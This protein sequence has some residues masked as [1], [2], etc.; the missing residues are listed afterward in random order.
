M[1]LLDTSHIDS[2]IVG[3]VDP[4]I[5]AFTTGTVPEYLKVGDT[6]RPVSVRLQ[7]WR[8][9]FPDLKK[10]YEHVAKTN[11]GKYFRD[12]AV[13][14]Y[15]ETI[16]GLHRLL[17][18]EL[19]IP[20][21]SRE[22]FQHATNEDIDKAI[23]DIEEYASK[24]GQTRYQFYSE[25]RLPQTEHYER[26]ETFEPRPNQDDTI[27]AFNVAREKG[28]RHL[29]MYAVM[30]FGK[31]FT[32]MCCATEM[33]AKVVLIVSA[34]ADVL[35]EWKYTVESH[36]RFKDYIFLDSADL[37][38]EPKAITKALD[39]KQCV[40]VFLTLQD[41]MGD[42]IKAKHKDLFK[43]TVDLL[44]VDET[45][46][47]ARAEEY[48][49]VLRN[50]KLSAAQIRKEQTNLDDTLDNLEQGLDQLKTLKTDTTLH[51][52]GTP[53]RILMGSEFTK[54]DII[55]FY[56]FTDIIDD[57]EKWDREHLKEDDIKEW[58]NPYY[59]FPQ[60]IRFAFHPNASSQRLLQ[61]MRENGLTAALNE[62]FRPA[63]I[64]QDTD[65]KYKQFAHPQEV[66]DLLE[67]IDGSQQEEDLLS[68]LDYSKLKEGKMCHHMVF[69]LP[70]CASCDAMETLLKKQKR[71]FK[72]LS[73]YEIINI[74][75]KDSVFS[76]NDDVKKRITEAEQAGKKT[77]SLTVNKMLTGCTVPEWDTMLFLK[78]VS[79]P[80]EYDQAIF[81]L[82]NQFVKRFID[83]KGDVVKYNMKP[84]TLLVDFDVNRMFIMQEQKSKIYNVN[85]T[86]RGNDELEKRI[87]RELQISPIIVSNK[88]KLVEATPVDIMD[89]V[90]QYSAT[91]TV[92]DE[93]LEIP[94]DFDLLQDPHI[95][96]IIEDL[97]PI[98]A[99]KGITIQPIEGEGDDYDFPGEQLPPSAGG[100]NN[101]GSS[102]NNESE[103][104]DDKDKRLATYFSQILFFALLT[105]KPAHSLN[106]IIVA[107]DAD[108]D[109]RRIAKHVGLNSRALTYL[110]KRLNP[111]HLSD[112]DYKIQN[113]ND[114]IR[115]E[116]VAPTERVEIALN[117]FGRLS[118]SEIVTP[119]HIADKMVALLPENEINEKTKFLDIASKE[120]EFA[121]ALYKRFGEKVKDNIHALPTSTLTYEFTRKVFSLL[122]IP[123]RNIIS[124]FNSYDLIGQNKEQYCQI[125][126]NMKFDVIVG[127]PPYQET[128][129]KKETENGQKRV[130][131]IFHH[132]QLLSDEIVTYSV[133]IYPGG[134]WI[135]QFGKGMKEFGHNQINDVHLSKM[136]YYPDANEIF[137]QVGISDGLSIVMK[138]KRKNL[139]GFSY[140]YCENGEPFEIEKSKSIGDDI[141]PL[142]P[143]NDCIVEHINK[144]VTKKG[145]T[146]LNESVLSQKLFS[147]E[148]DFVQSN[149]TLVRAYN[150]GDFFDKS[151]EIKLLTNDKAGKAGRARWY[152]VQRDVITSGLEYLDRWKVVVSS[153]NAGGQKRSNQL[154]ILDNYSAFGRVKVALKTFMTQRE[155][156]NFYNYVDSELIRFAFL[157]TDES[158]TSLAKQV[159]DIGNYTDQNGVIDFSKD[160]NAQLYHIFGIT[161]AE[162]KYIKGVL[163]KK[164]HKK[165]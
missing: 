36:V 160:I 103:E 32:S 84:Q 156:Q 93:A 122:G 133:M 57:K 129:A 30:R 17:P 115:D 78:D 67:I 69:V 41:L 63:S 83:E 27:K 44:I 52:S 104:K 138:D 157:L 97:E 75:G 40:A 18:N 158:L 1:T 64:S 26:K 107:V 89:A 77:I 150:D 145:Y 159:P 109:N 114:Q 25:D 38:A 140:T 87:T 125:L 144:T 146:Y 19:Q 9:F 153:A 108:A 56:Q 70:F 128:V 73:Q 90:R 135:Q 80:Q 10:Q 82:Q 162:Q 49:K 11:N 16:K 31:S 33:K 117:K 124:I 61:E 113:I 121:C 54:E 4:H 76:D 50:A 91:R 20:Y 7:E 154:E 37:V 28:R 21:Y 110:S 79:S 24:S 99:K 106:D 55:A 94:I 60:M 71:K 143:Q 22:F 34:K 116:S 13:H 102:S 111:F 141:M 62:L 72:N 68:F 65:G 2:I 15:L 45:H 66:L 98:N 51:L 119:P 23:L 148:S 46:F 8:A 47:G 132:F 152:I 123:I 101:G 96:H 161:K 164:S 59:G 3:R 134:R 126:K 112:L 85:T 142:N 92:M 100:T 130:S 149:P 81:R 120:G 127:N 58:D 39:Q 29:L 42:D 147:I 105:N 5:Y 86:Q 88:N 131:S 48:G 95:L 14:Y 151:S 139:F 118:N 165:E 137:T 74:A 163:E 53:Y 12:F 136:I 6:Y 155:A 43:N 35:E